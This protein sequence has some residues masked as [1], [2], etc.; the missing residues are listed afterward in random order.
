MTS[1][2]ELREKELLGKLQELSLSKSRS[3]FD[4]A[5]C[6]VQ[7]NLV[8][9]VEEVVEALRA[10]LSAVEMERDEA[11][12]WASDWHAVVDATCTILGFGLLDAD[13]VVNSVRNKFEASESALSAMKRELEKEARELER[14]VKRYEDWRPIS[15]LPHEEHLRRSSLLCFAGID[16]DDAETEVTWTGLWDERRNAFMWCLVNTPFTRELPSELLKEAGGNPDV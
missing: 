5:S 11:L 1:P 16:D 12:K 3:A 2:S 13:Q 9:E 6:G 10:R 7:A 15:E 8:N 4:C 14:M